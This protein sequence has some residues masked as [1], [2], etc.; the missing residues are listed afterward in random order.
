MSLTSRESSHES[1]QYFSPTATPS[2]T[3]STITEYEENE[4]AYDK[5]DAWIEPP[6][7]A[8]APSFEDD[9]QERTD[10]YVFQYMLPLGHLPP[11]HLIRETTSQKSKNFGRKNKYNHNI[12][13]PALSTT[14]KLD[15][16]VNGLRHQYNST[17]LCVRA[18]KPAENNC[19]KKRSSR[20]INPER[21]QRVQALKGR[22]RRSVSRRRYAT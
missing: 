7:K 11:A 14:D 8:P 19:R 10:Q 17:S 1:L 9:G 20:F 16:P 3:A 22:K 5:N 15:T 12:T 2:S 21:K 18:D 6:L 13:K 4:P